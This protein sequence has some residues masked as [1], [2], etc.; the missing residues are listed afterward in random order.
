MTIQDLK[1]EREQIIATIT[2]MVGADK[3]AQVMNV[4][5]GGIDS[6]S[7]IEECIEAS[8]SICEFTA[9]SKKDSKLANM[10]NNNLLNEDVHY[11]ILTKD[12]EKN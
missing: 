12:F 2:E 6:C 1:N 7:S 5:V 10:Y 3:V 11:N 4:M 8:I 9:T